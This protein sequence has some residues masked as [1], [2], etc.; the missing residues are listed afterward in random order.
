VGFAR[1]MVAYKQA[2]LLFRDL[3]KLKSIAEKAGPFQIVFAGKA[4]PRD[5]E[6]KDLIKR[7]FQARDALRGRVKLAYL[8]NYDWDQARLMV[9]GAGV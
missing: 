4:H 1:R 6:G 5:A 9:A 3:D 7:I 2:E 8:A